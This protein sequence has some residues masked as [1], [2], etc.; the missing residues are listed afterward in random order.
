MDSPRLSLLLISADA[1][2]ADEWVAMLQQ[3]VPMVE[4]VFVVETAVSLPQALEKLNH[5]P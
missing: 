5:A 3:S 1:Q 2:L 4:V